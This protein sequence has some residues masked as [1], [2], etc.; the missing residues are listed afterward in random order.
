MNIAPPLIFIAAA[1]LVSFEPRAANV[2][3]YGAKGDGITDDTGAVSTAIEAY[4]DGLLVFPAGK[5]RISRTIEIDLS[6]RGPMG[7]SGS[8]GSAAV[9]MEGTG[10]AFRIKGT[11]EGTALPST[12]KQEVWLRERMFILENIEIN[13]KNRQADGI[14]LQCLMQPVLRGCLIRGGKYGIILTRRNRNVLIEGNHIYDCSGVGVYLDSVNIHQIIISHNHISYCT[15]AGIRIRQGEIQNFQI[16]GNDIEYNCSRE[17]TGSAD[18]YIDLAKGGLVGEGTISGNTIQAVESKEGANIRFTGDPDRPHRLGL[19]SITGNH[20][21]NQENGILLQNTRGISITGNTFI[22]AYHRHI[23]ISN[24]RNI[25][26]KGNVIDYNTDYFTANVRAFGGIQ[27]TGSRDILLHA[28]IIDGVAGTAPG[29]GAAIEITDS[30]NI[31]L[32]NS[33]IL[34]TGR[35]GVEVVDSPDTIV[36]GNIIGLVDKKGIAISVKGNSAGTEITGNRSP[37][38][39]IESG[40][41][42]VKRNKY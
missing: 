3:D 17:L 37:G 40:I 32:K 16:T 8:G 25:V 41:A 31:S 18:I 42:R 13:A 6:K 27:I 20:I 22:R 1:L 10:P 2:K 35:R 39:R 4:N 34:N 36:E 24:S 26:F 12:V 28:N 30:R 11:H 33:R 19:W 15:E 9:I 7:I 14:E 23:R 5:Y 21:S 38:S 29:E